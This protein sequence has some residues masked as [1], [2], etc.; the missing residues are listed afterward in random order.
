MKSLPARAFA[1]LAA[2]MIVLHALF[3][4]LMPQARPGAVSAAAVICSTSNEPPASHDQTPCVAH[5]LLMVGGG[6]GGGLPPSAGEVAAFAQAEIQ[7]LSP[8]AVEIQH[9]TPAHRPQ[10]PRAPPAV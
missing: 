3:A 1:L 4:A 10:S 9:R 5:C 2:Y 7:I 8:Q 6:A